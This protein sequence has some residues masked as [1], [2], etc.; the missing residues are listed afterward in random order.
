MAC[1]RERDNLCLM[2]LT[3]GEFNNTLENELPT[4]VFEGDFSFSTPPPSPPSKT[5]HV[6]LFSRVLVP[7][8]H[9]HHLHPQIRAYMARFR[10]QLLL[11]ILSTSPPSKPSHVCSFSRVSNFFNVSN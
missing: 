5:S 10:G 7:H 1:F 4:F 3:A 8:Q 6:C 9:Q 11:L 2:Q